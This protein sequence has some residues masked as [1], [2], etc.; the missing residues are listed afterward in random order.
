MGLAASDLPSDDLEL[1]RGTI[2]RFVTFGRHWRKGLDSPTYGRAQH[3]AWR[4]VC[5]GTLEPSPERLAEVPVLLGFLE[6]LEMIIKSFPGG[7]DAITPT[8]LEAAI[9]QLPVNWMFW[10]N[11]V[12]THDLLEADVLGGTVKP[13]RD[14]EYFE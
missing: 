1:I 8:D 4:D 11:I 7:V 10:E 5:Y 6:K 14:N 13:F 9:D 2:A 12:Q 3:N